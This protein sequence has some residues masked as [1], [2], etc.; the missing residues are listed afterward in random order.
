MNGEKPHRQ[1]DKG[2]TTTRIAREIVD[3]EIAKR[4]AKTQRLKSARLASEAAEPAQSNKVASK[5]RHKSI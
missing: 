4:E 2:E 5:K 3:A 1:Q